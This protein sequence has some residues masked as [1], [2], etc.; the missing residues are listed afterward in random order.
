MNTLPLRRHHH[1]KHKQQATVKPIKA[2][3]EKALDAAIAMANALASKSMQDL[4]KRGLHLAGEDPLYNNYDGGPPAPSPLTPNSPSKKF[5]FW[6]PG[7][8]M[9]FFFAVLSSYIA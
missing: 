1:K 9:I 5:A 3:D 2:S 6:F 4:D 7:E 8:W